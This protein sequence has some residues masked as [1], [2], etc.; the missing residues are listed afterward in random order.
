MDAQ[1]VK[2]TIC[3]LELYFRTDEDDDDEDE[4]TT[5][6]RKRRNEQRNI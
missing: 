4:E 2:C 6:K 1:V 5:T 3:H